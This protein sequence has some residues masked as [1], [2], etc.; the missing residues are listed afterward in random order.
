MSINDLYDAYE[1]ILVNATETDAAH[2][3]IRDKNKQKQ[4]RQPSKGKRKKRKR[5]KR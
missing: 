4:N 1:I 5:R 2:K 3:N